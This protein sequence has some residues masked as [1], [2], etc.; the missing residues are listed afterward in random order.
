MPTPATATSPSPT[1]AKPPELAGLRPRTV[2]ALLLFLA[3][4]LGTLYAHLL[5]TAQSEAFVAS[6][7]R[8]TPTLSYFA[9]KHNVLNQWFVKWA[10]GWTTAAFAA[11]WLASPASLKRRGSLARYTLATIAFVAFTAWFFGPAMM[12]RVRIL[13]GGECVLPVP[14][15]SSPL[16][17]PQ[18]G[19]TTSSSSNPL[20]PET[21]YLLPVPAALCYS[22]TVLSPES[23]P[24]LFTHPGTPAP[25]P[26]FRLAPR[27]RKGHDV[28]G[29]IFL[30]TLAVLFLVDELALSWGLIWYARKKGVRPTLAHL[31]V[32][33]AVSALVGLWAW[34]VLMTSVWFHTPDE[35][36]SGYFIGLAAYAFSQIPLPFIDYLSEAR[37]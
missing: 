13:S 32:T 3:V 5:T 19:T 36:F 7:T 15:P 31:G 34:M 30:L 2:A 35:K 16:S 33:L 14:N 9:N 8:T 27:I 12:D 28:S 20:E 24:E 6:M 25:P 22:H 18:P 17:P 4:S 1:S 29:H 23:H 26:G 10:W 11:H 37:S 21:N